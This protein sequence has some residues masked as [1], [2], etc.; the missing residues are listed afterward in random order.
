VQG[1]G[2]GKRNVSPIGNLQSNSETTDG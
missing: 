2:L 1:M